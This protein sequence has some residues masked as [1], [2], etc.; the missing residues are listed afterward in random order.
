MLEFCPVC[1]KI[2]EIGGWRGKQVGKC[3]CGF[4]RTSGLNIQGEERIGSSNLTIGLAE[5]SFANEFNFNC[6]FCGFE[7]CK[8]LEAGEILNNE[9]SVTF[10]K[11]LS[12][13]KSS[14]K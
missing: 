1:K 8:V 5:E 12:C 14:R 3:S 7:K 9:K 10:F 6:P 2:L 4:I 13:G 11:C